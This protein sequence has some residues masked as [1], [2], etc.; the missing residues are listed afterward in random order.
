[1]HQ[2]QGDRPKGHQRPVRVC[3]DAHQLAGQRRAYKDQLATP[4]DLAVGAHPPYSGRRGVLGTIHP[5]GKGT[6]RWHIPGGR[7]DLAQRL[8]G[9]D[10]VVFEA[11]GVTALLLGRRRCRRRTHR[12]LLQRPVHPLVPSVLLRMPGLDPFW[13]D[14][15]LDPPDCQWGQAAHPNGG[16]ERAVVGADGQKQA[17]RCGLGGQDVGQT[18]PC[19]WTRLRPG[20]P[21]STPR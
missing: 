8:M 16:K 20:P 10:G 7:G 11:E 6:G 21:C 19:P 17:D 2:P 3:R 18:T 1:M 5:L 12:R 13:D 9:P 4:L 14:P 15:E